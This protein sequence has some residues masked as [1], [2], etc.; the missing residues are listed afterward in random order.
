MLLIYV[1]GPIT[2]TGAEA[3]AF[4]S[5][6]LNPEPNWPDVELMLLSANWAQGGGDY[7][8]G[9]ML[10]LKPEVRST[11]ISNSVL[12]FFLYNGSECL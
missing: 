8:N 12:Y 7:I 11:K 1:L 5:T 6:D 3:V 4:V 10:H 2:G 9:K